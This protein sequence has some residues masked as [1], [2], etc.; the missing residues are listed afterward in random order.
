MLGSITMYALPWFRQLQRRLSPHRAVRR[1]PVRRHV[2]HCLEILED[3][4]VPADFNVAAGD[5]NGL[6]ASVDQANRMGQ[7]GQSNIIKSLQSLLRGDI[8]NHWI[9]SRGPS[10]CPSG[11]D[12]CKASARFQPRRARLCL[13]ALEHRIAPTLGNPVWVPEGPGGPPTPT[14][15]GPGAIINPADA[16][17]SPNDGAVNGIAADPN[18]SN[19]MF[20]STVN[21]G[22]FRSV[23]AGPIQVSSPPNATNTPLWSPL[24]DQS[25]S[26][27]MTDVTFAFNTS[28]QID[29][30]TLYA[31]TG[32]VSAAGRDGGPR[33][34]V[35]KITNAF[36]ANPVVS[37]PLGK[38]VNGTNLLAGLTINRIVAIPVKD[39]NGVV[40]NEGVVAATRSGGLF[41]SVDGGTT[42]QAVQV[43]NLALNSQ[44]SDLVRDPGDTSRL[45]AAVPGQGVFVSND[46]G[47]TWMATS[48]TQLTNVATSTRIG[49]AVSTGAVFVG[50]LGAG[51]S[52]TGVF[53]SVDQGTTWTPMATPRD[54]QGLMGTQGGTNFAM[55]ADPNNSNVLFVSGSVLPGQVNSCEVFRGD[56]SQPA[57]SQWTLV[58]VGGANGTAP[59]PD[60]RQMVFDATGNLILATDGGYTACSV[61][62]CPAEPGCRWT[63]TSRPPSSTPPPGTPSTTSSSAAPRTTPHRARVPPT[64]SFGTT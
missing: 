28:G 19:N 60:S 46:A 52:L 35:Y 31:S 26:L 64:T 10:G 38:D 56:A 29:P 21:G 16:L 12:R 57:G 54:S 34:G 4:S 9:R 58:V 7:N 30:N 15:Q 55:V 49:L 8:L 47:A 59:A 20:I 11:K 23:N 63:A 42:W 17:G 18:T 50:L 39:T 14:Q 61:P 27:S 62:T 41:R 45:Y 48:N 13:E 25:P 37:A 40:V 2:R 32:L 44:I 22:V 33:V 6:I 43:A 51:G 3:R 5:V 36:S 1:V 24:T 53:R